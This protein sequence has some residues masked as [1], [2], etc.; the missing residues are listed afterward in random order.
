MR[1]SPSFGAA[2]VGLLAVLSM[3][4]VEAETPATAFQAAAD[5]FVA[6]ASAERVVGGSLALVVDGTVVG[7]RHVGVADA[8][9]GD[10]VDRDTIYHWA[11][12]TKTFTAIAAMQ[13]V[14]RGL[15]SLDDPVVKYVPEFAAVRSSFGPITDVRIR[16]LLEHS[17][18]LREGTWPWNADG[19][20]ERPS[21]QRL[22]PP[23]WPQLAAM[24]PYTALTFAPGTQYAYSNPGTTLLGRVVETIAHEDL[25]VYVDKNILRPLGMTRTYFDLTPYHLAAHRSNSYTWQGDVRVENGREFDT[26]VTSGNGGLN[27]PIGDMVKYV[28]F[29][30]G[31]GDRT[32]Y[33]QVLPRATL[34]GMWAPRWKTPYDA[35]VDERMAT[36]FFT[37][38]AEGDDGRTRRFIGHTGSQNGY[39]A[40]VYVLPEA[41]AAVVMAVNTTVPVPRPL[42]FETRR[43]LFRTVFPRIPHGR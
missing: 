14:Q 21:W 9:A 34:E 1:R 36:S 40:F 38:D 18:G 25:E 23:G 24:M 37:I 32:R 42:V 30:L 19:E 33:A 35:S 17:S 7:E 39:R 11:S 12:I 6:R 8:V 28:N 20:R 43:D 22:E 27:A 5:R 4:R 16:H 3:T 10:T 31:V 29:L 2:L 41:R 13:L 15:L 26:G